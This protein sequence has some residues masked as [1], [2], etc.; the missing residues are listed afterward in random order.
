VAKGVGRTV[1]ARLRSPCSQTHHGRQ[2]QARRAC[3][4]HPPGSRLVKRSW[5]T[6]A[7]ASASA[8]QRPE[9]RSE[10][11]A[12]RESPSRSGIECPPACGWRGML[13]YLTAAA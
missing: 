3:P 5:D 12:V 9:V 6:V 4:D 13:G 7:Q 8:M 11:H 1:S 2:V 10:R